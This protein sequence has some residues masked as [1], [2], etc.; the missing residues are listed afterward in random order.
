[1]SA[2]TV[3]YTWRYRNKVFPSQ[4]R[5]GYGNHQTLSRNAAEIIEEIRSTHVSKD[6]R[7]RP[8]TEVNFIPTAEDKPN[9]DYGEKNDEKI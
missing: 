7:F 5:A 9:I 3:K 4:E 6:Y 8:Q 1:M 2:I